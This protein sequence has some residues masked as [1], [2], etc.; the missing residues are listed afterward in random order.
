MEL[1]MGLCHDSRCDRS[2]LGVTYRTIG[3]EKIA[4]ERIVSIGDRAAL[5]FNGGAALP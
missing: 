3:R 1:A 5:E 2:A 4:Q